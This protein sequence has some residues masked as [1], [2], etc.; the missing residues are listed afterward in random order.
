MFLFAVGPPESNGYACLRIVVVAHSG[1]DVIPELDPQTDSIPK[2]VLKSAADI[3]AARNVEGRD[4]RN[5]SD[6]KGTEP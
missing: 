6:D 2:P 5:T 4:H 3:D 1:Q